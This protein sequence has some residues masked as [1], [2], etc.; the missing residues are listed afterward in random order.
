MR[1][2]EIDQKTNTRDIAKL[3]QAKLG[4]FQRVGGPSRV[5][6][7]LG[8]ETNGAVYVI[9]NTLSALGLGW[10]KGSKQIKTVYLWREPFTIYRSADYAIDILGD[11]KDSQGL[12]DQ[13]IQMLHDPI[14]GKI[15]ASADAG[16]EETRFR[17][18]R[19]HITPPF[20]EARLNEA[21]RTTDA[22][23]I[24]MARDM[25][26]AKA[27][28]LSLVDL[29]NIG[30]KNDVQVPTTI[31]MGKDYKTIK[32]D[33]RTDPHHWNLSGGSG[34]SEEATNAEI[35][36][37]LGGTVERPPEPEVSPEYQAQL[38][39]AKAKSMT[40]L[41]GKGKVYLM[42]RKPNGAFFRIPGL[43]TYSAQLERLLA[44]QLEV[45]GTDRQSMEE[46]YELL[47]DKVRLVAAGQSAFIKS[48]LITGAPSSGKALALDTPIPTPTGWTTMGE[49]KVNDKI[50]DDQGQI[51]NVTFATPI[52]FNR[53]CYEVLFDDGTKIIADADHRWL[54]KHK[55]EDH[56]QA[57]TSV[58]NT[59]VISKTLRFHGKYNHK[60][61]NSKP[62]LGIHQ[63]SW[64]NAHRHKNSRTIIGCSPVQSVPV[65]CITVDSSS[66]LFLCSRSFIPTH[67]TFNVMSEIKSLGLKDGK[68]YI[69]KK[70]RITVRSMY[71]TLIEQINGLVIFD[72]CD[73]VVDDKNGINMLKGA[74][75]TDPV[76]EISY[77]VR[78]A[79]RTSIMEPDVRE[80]T[81]NAMSRVL[82]GKPSPEDLVR[83][84]RFAK[85]KKIKEADD[86]DDEPEDIED[87]ADNDLYN[88]Q[89]YLTNH[90]PDKIDFQ[91]RII[92][93][94]NMD[95]SDWDSAIL[96][97]T[98]TINMNFTSSEML[99]YI[100][101]IKRHI[102][103]PNLNDEQKQEVMDY[104]RGLWQTG[105]LKRQVNFRLIQQAFDLRLT[106]NWKKLCA[107]L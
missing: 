82:R 77:D 68:D 67:N 64:Q 16:D 40:T 33:G 49:L 32:P 31:K 83:F 63:V 47:R 21:R 59:E 5:Y 57:V 54:T 51:C 103:T 34:G 65:R 3:L 80:E 89:E 94:S 25:F 92:F 90:L 78:G 100:D 30:I 39:L 62:I 88:I 107:E 73:S 69:I 75:D 26:G 46:Q 11:V 86:D 23:F 55:S 36:K 35:G 17:A 22:E 12:V 97:R 91:G 4:R 61:I 101:K 20:M 79:I 81:V 66:S 106:T 13:I 48:L 10:E 96:T 9:G 50:F 52:Q 41:V 6:E 53:D 70:G 99:D 102:H 45:Q 87:D 42:G 98:F 19:R 74:L 24:K 28:S 71:R 2:I 8:T 29:N 27:N 43:E 18:T 105:K 14:Y 58:I 104:V 60:I 72:D 93:I 84:A 38:D 85:G 95:E 15:S 1:L 37:E 44:N 76:R 7:I 56:K